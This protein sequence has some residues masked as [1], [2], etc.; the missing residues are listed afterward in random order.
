MHVP[1]Q[2]LDELREQGFCVVPG[3][4]AADELAAAVEGLWLD[5]PTPEAYF[6]APDAHPSYARSQFAGL[7]TF[8]A[9]SWAVNRLAFHPDLVDAVE[10]FLGSTDLQLYKGEIWAK[11]AGAV[12]Y[13]Q[14]LHRDFGNH[15]LVVPRLDGFAMQVTSFIL[16]SDVTD[17]DAPTHVVSLEHSRDVE[18]VP[19]HRSAFPNSLPAGALAGHEVAVTGP[20]GTLLLYRTDVLHRGT[21]FAAPGRARFAVLAD[22]Q[23]RG[24][25]WAGKVAWPD[26]ALQ[27]AFVEVMERAD[28]RQRDLFGFPRPGDPYW[29]AQTWRDVGRRYPRMDMGPYRPDRD[30]DA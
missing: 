19:D 13:D 18:L 17:L 10:R 14:P 11:Y 26:H 8:P 20:A 1:D 25:S 6:A 5:F 30:A 7:R 9:R 2:A 21:D 28:V 29:N 3:F 23:V 4:L 16:L 22:Y 24:P 12:D 15:S 27:P